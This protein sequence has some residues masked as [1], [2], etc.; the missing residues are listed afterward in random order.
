MVGPG[1]ARAGGAV[2]GDAEVVVAGDV[3]AVVVSATVVDVGGVP[4]GC[5]G[6]ASKRI[7]V[8]AAVDEVV[9]SGEVS[10]LSSPPS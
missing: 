3:V 1:C 2:I 7:V 6:G 5:G 4:S 9:G 8:G 10:S